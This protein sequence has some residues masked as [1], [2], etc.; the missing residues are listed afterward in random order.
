MLEKLD[1]ISFQPTDGCVAVLLR[2][3]RQPM[4][5]DFDFVSSGVADNNDG[6]GRRK[7]RKIRIVHQLL[8]QRCASFFGVFGTVRRIRQYNVKSFGMDCEGADGFEGASWADLDL[9]RLV[10]AG[11]NIFFDVKE[12]LVGVFHAEDG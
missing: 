8:R 7:Q 11:S 4:L 2:F 6:I 12:V 10:S 3:F 5:R 1:K 9:A